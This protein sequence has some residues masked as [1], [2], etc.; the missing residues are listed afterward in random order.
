M[1]VSKFV[2][3]LLLRHC[4]YIIIINIIHIINNILLPMGCIVFIRAP[5]NILLLLS[6]SISDSTS[7]T[8]STPHRV[9]FLGSSKTGRRRIAPREYITQS[10]RDERGYEWCWHHQRRVGSCSWCGGGCV[11][12]RSIAVFGG[13]Y[14][15]RHTHKVYALM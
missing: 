13:S 8:L 10:P 12:S 2:S 15:E 11:G 14:D 7:A 9:I 4:K 6:T 1:R 5:T 3:I